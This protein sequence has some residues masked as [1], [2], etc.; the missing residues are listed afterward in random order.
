MTVLSV[1][2]AVVS[3]EI[4]TE[5][6]RNRKFRKLYHLI[7]LMNCTYFWAAQPSLKSC[8]LH[9]ICL[10]VYVLYI[11]LLWFLLFMTKTFMMRTL[12]H[13]VFVYAKKGGIRSAVESWVSETPALTCFV[14][15]VA[16][17]TR[18]SLGN[19][20]TGVISLGYQSLQQRKM[21]ELKLISSM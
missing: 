16:K 14:Y 20:I 18:T 1:F 4:N 21:P 17:W 10:Y 15:Y 11:W 5:A 8:F 3:T 13:S 7:G 9:R 19:G 2:V 6:H 12:I